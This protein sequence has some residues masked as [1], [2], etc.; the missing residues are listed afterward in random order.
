MHILDEEL[1]SLL[2]ILV[3]GGE[4]AGDETANDV[5]ECL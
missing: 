5:Q 2:L 3:R 4:K 1:K